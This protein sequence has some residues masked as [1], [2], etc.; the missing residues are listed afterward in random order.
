MKSKRYRVEVRARRSD[1]WE[2]VYYTNSLP[3]AKLSA[4]RVRKT[5]NIRH[6]QV[7]DQT[8]ETVVSY[9]PT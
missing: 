5:R 8:T 1:A 6:T 4:A 7:V 2:I 9:D 3:V